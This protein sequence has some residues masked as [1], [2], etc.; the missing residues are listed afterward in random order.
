[1]P[2]H[3]R[4]FCSYSSVDKPRVQAIVEQLEAAGIDP[5]WDGWEI[6]PG[7]NFVAR[8]NEGLHT[9]AAGLIFF[10]KDT[11]ASSWAQQEIHTLTLKAVEDGIPLFLVMLDPDARLPE[12]LRAIHR[13]DATQIKALIDAIYNTVAGRSQK[14]PL[15]P[16]RATSRERVFQI[17]LQDAGPDALQVSAQLDGATLGAAQQ[18]RLSSDFRFSYHD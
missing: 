6:N 14:P 16:S 2:D 9:C 8:I 10:S 3:P 7:D 13:L 12:L 11:L 4:V 18:V 5:W 15:R 1:M 17:A